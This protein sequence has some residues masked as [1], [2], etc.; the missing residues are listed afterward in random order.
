MMKNNV[1]VTGGTGFLGMQIIFQL[2]QKGYPVKTTVRS[3]NS[4]AKIME[5]LTNNGISDF[6]KLSFVEVDLSKDDGWKDAMADCKY[7]LSVASPVFFGKFEN[8]DELIRP[9]IEGIT[10]ILSAAKE[11][12][13]KRVVMTS[14]F[15]A[16][17]F[18]NMDKTTITTEE[19]WT[20][21]NMKGLSA[22]EK[23]KLLAE[24][25]AWKFMEDETEL[26]FTTINPVAIFGPSQSNHVSGSFDLLKSLLNG[27]MKRVIDIP[28]NVVDARDVADLHIRAMIT[29]LAK[30]ERFIASADGEI[31]MADIAE[32]LRQERPELVKNMPEKTLPNF[33]IKVAALFNQQAKE[34]KL[35]INMNRHISN[36][37]AK[38]LL[39]WTPIAT[40]EEAVLAAVDSLAKYGLLA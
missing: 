5:I 12:K 40:K 8:E 25:A 39:G 26:E 3:L 34:G 21:E 22:Y 16:V 1:L 27:S 14:N 37:K 15:G 36:S 19:N 31:S 9:A 13:V 11:A 10:R 28:L 20:D 18:S 24:K 17:G 32:L 35:L 7:V 6:S 2:L 4:K 29:P 33:A 23:S 30:G 38:D